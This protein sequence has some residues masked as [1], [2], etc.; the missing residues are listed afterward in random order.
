MIK[1]IFTLLMV[2]LSTYLGLSQ[3]NILSPKELQNVSIDSSLS[4]MRQNAYTGTDLDNFHAIG[5][6]TLKRSLDSESPQT[7]AEVHEELANWHGYNGIFP[8]DSIVYHSEKALEYYEKSGNKKKIADTYR[9]LSIDY[10]NIRE[11]EK[12][13]EVLF[14]AIGLYEELDDEKGL[15]SAYR[16]LGVLYQVMEDFEKSIAYTNKAIPILENAGEYASVAI[17]QFNLIIG[18]GELGEFDKAYKAADYCLEL[19]KTKA[20]E[21][22]FVPVRAYSYRGEVYVKAKDYDNALKDYIKAWELCKTHVG[23]ERCA[24]YRTEIGQVYL[25]KNDYSNALTHLTAGVAAYED[26]EQTSIIQPYLDLSATYAGLGDFEN[27]LLYKD[28]AL[29]NKIEV[30]EGKV[31]NLETETIVKYE[32]GKKDEALAS[33]ALLLV[34]KSKTQN[35]IIAV[36]ALLGLLLVS[37]L[38]FFNK[39]RKATKIIKAKNA[40]NELLL[41]EI[42]HRVKNNLEMVKSLIALQSA[43]IEDSATKDAMIAS[44]NRVQSM[45]IIHQ[46]LYQGENLGSIEM[47]DYFLNLSEGILDTFNAEDRVKIECAME[48]LDLDVDTAVP[49]GLIVNELLTN[50]LKYAFPENNDGAISISLE[51][52]NRS[53]LKLKVSDNGVGKIKGL[54]PKGTGFGTQLVKLLTQ[55]LNGKMTEY[56]ESG[57]YIEF[58]FLID[59]AA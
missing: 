12:S 5:L 36:T 18:Y 41:K 28:K 59:T 46:K 4:W 19:I 11:L 14:K 45:G 56:S 23:E 9:T 38:Y 49:I 43:Q 31:A 17:A 35:L 21:E 58:D 3:S 54:A 1:T 34:Q 13:Q 25:M 55:Q 7:I 16:T 50:A 40:E 6:Q 30:L 20:P 44:Q 37:L 48:N 29:N 10:L 22:I 15:G 42:H 33:Q 27:A 52:I 57:T 24:T 32:T 53:H 26:K 2:C 47:K 39:N 8:S 51:K